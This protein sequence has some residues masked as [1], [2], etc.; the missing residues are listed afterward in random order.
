M[1]Q[2]EMQVPGSSMKPMRL[3]Q[4]EVVLVYLLQLFYLFNLVYIAIHL[5]S[6]RWI[7]PC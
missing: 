3:M 5:I 1:I 2:D 6:V 7:K 4:L